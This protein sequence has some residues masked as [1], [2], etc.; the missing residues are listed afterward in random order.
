MPLYMHACWAASVLSLC[1]PVDY[2]PPGSS[3]SGILQARLLQWVAMP[4]SRA[5]SRPRDQ[6]HVSYVS[7]IGRQVLYH[8]HLGSP[9]MYIITFFWIIYLYYLFQKMSE[10]MNEW[11]KWSEEKKGSELLP[12]SLVSGE[13]IVLV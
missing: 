9:Y 12:I 11:M 4:S 8:Y 10:E 3:V 2:S 1:D 13:Y 7:F 5:P 6:T